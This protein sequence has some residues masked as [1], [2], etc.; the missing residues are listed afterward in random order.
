MSETSNE[1]FGND[2]VIEAA[3]NLGWGSSR[4]RLADLAEQPAMEAQFVL[5]ALRRHLEGIG[6]KQGTALLHRAWSPALE[7]L[8]KQLSDAGYT[9]TELSHLMI[10]EAQTRQVPPG[11]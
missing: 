5:L 7:A 6:D 11:T 10:G 1:R 4:E 3:F 8:Q 2:A 9:N